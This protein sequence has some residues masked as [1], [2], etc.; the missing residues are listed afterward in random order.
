MS[1]SVLRTHLQTSNQK[2]K[3]LRSILDC[4]LRFPM[5]SSQ[6]LLSMNFM[7]DLQFLYYVLCATYVFNK[8][9]GLELLMH[10]KLTVYGLEG[11]HGS[12][13]RYCICL[14]VL[15]GLCQSL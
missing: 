3:N 7:L 5:L 6:C 14:V 9:N 1:D 4:R 12:I 8:V 15:L 13:L 11:V 10:T 2:D